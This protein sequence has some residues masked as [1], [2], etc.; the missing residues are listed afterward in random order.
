MLRLRIK[1]ISYMTQ[2]NI[3]VISSEINLEYLI[4]MESAKLRSIST[5]CRQEGSIPAPYSGSPKFKFCPRDQLS[6]LWFIIDSLNQIRPWPFPLSS[7]PSHHFTNHPNIQCY[8]VSATLAPFTNK[9]V[10]TLGPNLFK[11]V[12]T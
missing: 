12:I 3:D 11:K 7:F 5:H 1:P 10:R 6:W 4:L 2:P 9:I 8:T